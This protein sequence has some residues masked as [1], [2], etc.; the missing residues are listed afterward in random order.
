MPKVESCVIFGRDLST[1][2]RGVVPD[3]RSFA[4]AAAEGRREIAATYYAFICSSG[5]ELTVAMPIPLE[6]R[7]KFAGF[8]R[9]TRE[10]TEH[11]DGPASDY[12]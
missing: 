12:Y 1:Y 10:Y 3:W 4:I 11:P 5:S 9:A 8:L 2:H 7:G 6:I